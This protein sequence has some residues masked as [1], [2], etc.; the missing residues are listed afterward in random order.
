MLYYYCGDTQRKFYLSSV[1]KHKLIC[2]G[3]LFLSGHIHEMNLQQ[4]PNLIP[5]TFQATDYW[6]VSS[7][8]FITFL[9]FYSHIHTVW[10]VLSFSYYSYWSSTLTAKSSLSASCWQASPVLSSCESVRAPWEEPLPIA[11]QEQQG[12][13]LVLLFLAQKWQ[14]GPGQSSQ[15]TERALPQTEELCV[16]VR[17]H[18][19]HTALVNGYLSMLSLIEL[20]HL[21]D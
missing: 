5:I 9:I 12:K 3:L 20:K 2:F 18:S 11:S 6:S 1:C 15:S 13:P 19:A 4:T 8:C 21:L 17:V 16:Q 14:E 7:K 10:F